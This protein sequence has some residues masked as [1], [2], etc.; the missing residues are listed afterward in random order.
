MGTAKTNK[1]A[2]CS[3]CNYVTIYTG[4]PCN[5]KCPMCK[6]VELVVLKTK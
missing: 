1:T 4:C 6:S 2:K 5:W 3:K